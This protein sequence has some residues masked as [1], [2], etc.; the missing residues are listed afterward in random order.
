MSESVNDDEKQ[1]TVEASQR[2]KEQGNFTM[3]PNELITADREDLSMQAKMIWIELYKFIYKGEGK[4]AFPGMQTI[5]DDLN[6]STT[7]ARKYRKELEGADLL[8]VEHTGFNKSNRYILYSPALKANE[9]LRTNTSSDGKANTGSDSYTNTSSDSD[10]K[11][12]SDE[13]DEGCN[14]TNFKKKKSRTHAHAREASA[15]S[16]KYDKGATEY[17]LTTTLIDRIKNFT[18]GHTSV[19]PKDVDNKKLQNWCA[20]FARLQNEGPKGGGDAYESDEILKVIN[21]VFMEQPWSWAARL[22][23]AHYLAQHINELYR[24]M[25]DYED[26]SKRDKH[27][28]KKSLAQKIKEKKGKA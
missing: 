4:K 6:T 21:W 18:E 2:L 15:A 23:S 25:N 22:K 7:T 5:A 3:V 20:V 12:Y 1:T 9:Q 28:E 24:Q 16:K 8:D 19:P 10:R 13:K 27:G 17:N 26:W 14:K 11:A